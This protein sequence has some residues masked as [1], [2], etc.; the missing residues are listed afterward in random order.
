M[1]ILDKS[2]KNIISGYINEILNKIKEEITNE[3]NILTTSFS[4][5]NNF[6]KI[7][8][9]LNNFKSSIFEQFNSTL[10]SVID[11]FHQQIFEKFY[12]DY[13][14]NNVEEYLQ[15]SLKAKFGQFSFLN[16]TFNLTDI[17]HE[18]IKI[19]TNEYMLLSI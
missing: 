5:S 3:V 19:L 4:F 2:S 13:I 9:T 11:E 14:Q 7:E 12:S 1:N 15:Y 8:Q 6:N 16:V 10:T 18:N 17:M